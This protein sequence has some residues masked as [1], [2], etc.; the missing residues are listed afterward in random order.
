[1][2][3]TPMI[4]NLKMM[5]LRQRMVKHISFPRCKVIH[6]TESLLSTHTNAKAGL[7]I[8]NSNLTHCQRNREKEAILVGT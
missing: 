5:K 7:L 8:I 1:M 2:N 4:P 3:S 6:R